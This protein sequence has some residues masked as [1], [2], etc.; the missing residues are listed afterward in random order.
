MPN[1]FRLLRFGRNLPPLAARRYFMTRAPRPGKADVHRVITRR[2]IFK[3][4]NFLIAGCI[5]MICLEIYARTVLDRYADYLAEGAEE[6]EEDEEGA[7]EEDIEEVEEVVEKISYEPPAF[8]PFP[9]FTKRIQP[10]PYRSSDPEWKE[11]VRINRDAELQKV[12][13]LDLAE[14]ACRAVANHPVMKARFGSNM[15]VDGYWL[16][17]QYPNR[18]PPVYHRQG[19]ALS[20]DGT[21]EWREKLVDSRI[22]QITEHA[23]WPDALASSLWS[24]ASSLA[25]Q[26]AMSVAKMFGYGAKTEPVPDIKKAMEKLQEMQK[27]NSRKAGTDS[28]SLPIPGGDTPSKTNNTSLPPL[29]KKSPGAGA[30]PQTMPT[31]AAMSNGEQDVSRDETLDLVEAMRLH[32]RGPGLNFAKKLAETWRTPSGYPPRG[33]VSVSGL[34]ELRASTACILVDCNAWWDPKTKQFAPKHFKL[35][36]R[37]IRPFV[38][39][40][41]RP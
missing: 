40:P 13:E 12:I 29:R 11:F 3:P 16:I 32:M 9:G 41:S 35:K 15:K 17:F 25:V 27:Q 39:A 30:A 5:Y 33:A 7:T 10:P 6:E 4:S 14:T 34:V 36:L 21:I 20:K 2:R 26:N 1:M 24:F 8:I 18:P 23:L 38:Q 19:L 28:P 37:A 22:A 31:G